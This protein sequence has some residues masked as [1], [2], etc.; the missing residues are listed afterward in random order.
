MGV[1]ID[2]NCHRCHRL[3]SAQQMDHAASPCGQ[4]IV[5][6]RHI[7]CTCMHTDQCTWLIGAKSFNQ[8]VP[9]SLVLGALFRSHKSRYYC[10]PWI[11]QIGDAISDQHLSLGHMTIDTFFT[12]SLGDGRYIGFQFIHKFFHAGIIFLYA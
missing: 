3:I 10:S 7:H 12:S 11:Q 9:M 2:S 5:T 6:V 4:R 8:T 1:G